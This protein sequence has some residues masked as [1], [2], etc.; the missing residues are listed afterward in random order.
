ML[1]YSRQYYSDRIKDFSES[2]LGGMFLDL[3][4]SVGDNLSFYLDSQFNELDPTTA[5]ETVN[6][7]RHL[8]SS[9][10]KIVGAAPATVEQTI[11]IQIP[12][13]TAGNSTT[14]RETTIPIVNAGTRFTGDNGVTY[15]LQNDIDFRK[16]NDAG[17]YVAKVNVGK[18]T[19]SGVIQTYVMAATGI[20]VS[21]NETTETIDISS[22]FVPFRQI[23]LSNPDVSQIITV[24]DT[25]GNDYYEVSALTD[26]V[27][28]KNIQNIRYDIDEA[29]DAIK[30]I[31]VPYRFM[32]QTSLNNR[33]TTLTF[34]GG[35]ADSLEDDILPDPSS[36]AI[37]FPYR[38]TF[39]REALNPNNIISS[40]QTLGTAA[41]NTQL[42]I[43]YRYGG[44]LDHNAPVNGI[45]TI[46]TLNMTFPGNP[47]A[48]IAAAIRGSIETT[49]E[50]P[51][52]GGEDA[53][54][55]DEI[56]Q[57]IPS[58][59]K[60][61]ERIVTRE[62]LISRVYQMPSNFGRVFR[63]AVRSS[64]TNPLATQ[65]YVISRSSDGVLALTSDTVKEN[66]VKYIDPYRMISDAIDI[67]DAQVI[68]LHVEF[69]VVI[70]QSLNKQTVVASIL[71]RLN[72]FFRQQNFHIDQPIVLSEVRA[73]IFAIKGVISINSLRL[74]NSSGTINNRLY[75]DKTYD[76][77]AN[78]I[79]DV[80][81][82]PPGGIFELRY[83]NVDIV[84]RTV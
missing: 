63:A 17:N 47:P 38:R 59:R 69:E 66:I 10:V 35:S 80:I 22:T 31:P 84:G 61:Q 28:Y 53:P 72:D 1:D 65:L 71:K 36:F 33:L 18:T 56:R 55:L 73:S 49:N 62:D 5:Y 76:F 81:I 11:F 70:D 82:P 60:S 83:P 79:K 42:Q 3:A 21:G 67:L 25:L 57:Q 14:P 50:K 30:V 24:S 51:G 13:D 8:V 23:T 64:P 45:R 9:G 6:I 37:S 15:T 12:A 26:D 78:T 44:G 29:A 40:T 74:T 7:E 2:S 75:S 27:V 52:S 58:A 4:A 54:T 41:T 20:V 39:S 48:G 77:D 43:T 68:N 19:P 46:Q 34:G 16:R 32:S